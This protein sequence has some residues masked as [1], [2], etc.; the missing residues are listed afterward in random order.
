MVKYLVLILLVFI[1]CT[2]EPKYVRCLG[3]V[4]DFSIHMG[5]FNVS[6]IVVVVL[7]DGNKYTCYDKSVRTGNYLYEIDGRLFL[8]YNKPTNH[9]ELCP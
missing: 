9:S 6:D 5:S 4:V 8:R 7:D 2:S 3:K 1:G